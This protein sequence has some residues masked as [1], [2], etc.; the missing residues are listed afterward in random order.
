MAAAQRLSPEPQAGLRFVV[1]NLHALLPEL[2][3]G[4]RLG[5][6]PPELEVEVHSGRQTRGVA[7]V[8]RARREF[9]I[10]RESYLLEYGW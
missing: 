7:L 8:P 2:Q 9:R 10:A 3:E 6:V 4:L 5:E 1:E